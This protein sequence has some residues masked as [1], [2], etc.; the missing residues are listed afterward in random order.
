MN[1]SVNLDDQAQ[2]SYMFFGILYERDPFYA[3]QLWAEHVNF[4]GHTQIALINTVQF[5]HIIYI[6]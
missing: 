2:L 6:N 5:V 4:N 3:K 1:Q